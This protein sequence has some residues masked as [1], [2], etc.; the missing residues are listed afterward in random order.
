MRSVLLLAWILFAAGPARAELFIERIDWEFALPMKGRPSHFE[1]VESLKTDPPAFKGKL[2]AQLTL[3]NRGPR[4]MEGILLRY[5][6]SARLASL[7]L[8]QEGTWA[9]PFAVEE[10][11][12]P[13]VGA[14]QLLKVPLGPS[15][16]LDLYLKRL[17]R[18]G[19]WP[20]QIKIQV[21][22]EPHHQEAAALQ[23]M[24]RILPF[25]R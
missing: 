4:P 7:D 13:R 6:L 16:M 3:K 10:R 15:P 11:R 23:V 2:R 18:I 5:A 1:A 9:V 25:R 12:V 19:L 22:I 14:N 8:G 17:K 21:M 24:E 20:D